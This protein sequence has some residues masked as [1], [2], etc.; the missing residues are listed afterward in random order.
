MQYYAQKNV[1]EKMKIPYFL[2]V[3][4]SVIQYIKLY[5]LKFKKNIKWKFLAVSNCSFSPLI[6]EGVSDGNDLREKENRGKY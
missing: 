1:T 4:I 3:K 2:P 6:G 5:F